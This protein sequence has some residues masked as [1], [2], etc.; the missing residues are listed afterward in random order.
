[1]MNSSGLS[2]H[3]TITFICRETLMGAEAVAFGNAVEVSAFSP[4]TTTVTV[5]GTF[6]CIEGGT[7]CFSRPFWSELNHATSGSGA[8]V[9][10]NGTLETGRYSRVFGIGPARLSGGGGAGG[11]AVSGF[12]DPGADSLGTAPPPPPPA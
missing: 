1:M 2:G 7:F 11:L 5:D 12:P 8:R 9:C 4:P 3:K 10:V 6:H